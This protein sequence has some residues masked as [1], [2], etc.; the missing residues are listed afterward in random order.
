MKWL[1]EISFEPFLS[2]FGGIN[3]KNSI[4]GDF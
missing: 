4:V 3:P 1:G 2:T